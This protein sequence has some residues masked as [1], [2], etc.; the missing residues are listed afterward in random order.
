MS[1]EIM[2]GA[3]RD[4]MDSLVV[5]PD[6]S[7]ATHF[8]QQSGS[9]PPNPTQKIWGKKEVNCRQSLSYL[10]RRLCIQTWLA[11]VYPLVLG[12]AGQDLLDFL[13]AFSRLHFL[14]PFR[15]D[16]RR[17]KVI[18]MGGAQPLLSMLEGAKD[19]RTRREA[20]RALVALSRSGEMLIPE[21]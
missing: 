19:D 4:E 10:P 17:M 8:G 6:G 16:E 20:L 3:L 12:P 1:W 9:P 11:S 7:M 15:P 13:Q 2:K 14:F 5:R 21:H 18:E